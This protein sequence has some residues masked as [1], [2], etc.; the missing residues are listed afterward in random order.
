[1]NETTTSWDNWHQNL[2]KVIKKGYQEEALTSLL[3]ALEQLVNA[4]SGLATMYVVGQKPVITNQRL[5]ANEN[6]HLLINGYSDGAYLLD[7]FYRLATDE[8]QTGV[9]SLHQI[10]PNGFNESE[11]YQVFYSQLSLEDEVCIIVKPEKDVM[12]SL[13]VVRQEGLPHF[14]AQELSILE[15]VFPVI[16]AIV[17]NSYLSNRTNRSGQLDWQLDEALKL[18]GSSV[19]TKRECEVLHLTLQGY[20]IKYIADKLDNAP[21]TIKYHRKNLY[22]K[23]DINS[24]SELF[25]LF[26]TAL[27]ALPRGLMDDPLTFIE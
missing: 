15:R 9:F 27:K 3:F 17:V 8:Q 20:S 1:M 25:H 2:A 18:F 21:E 12:F 4:T 7:P 5:L 13:S 23:L 6:K 22:R 16:E 24:Q 14:S 10:A 26:I 19:L 11:Y